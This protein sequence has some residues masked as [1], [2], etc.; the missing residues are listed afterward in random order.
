MAFPAIISASD[1][2]AVRLALGLATTDTTTLPDA[3]ITSRLFGPWVERQVQR[4]VTNWDDVID[5]FHA[6]YDADQE[7]ALQD[8][9]VLWIASRLAALYF[10][11]RAGEEVKK[12][13]LGPQSVEWR[14]PADWMDVATRLAADAATEL[15]RVT[16]WN[17][18]VPVI[19]LA[20]R[21]GPTQARSVAEEHMTP[22]AWEA[23]IAPDVIKERRW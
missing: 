14:D 5:N 12:A 17:N 13:T 10:A 3:T 8:G 7:A 18:E 20:T 1:Y 11:R 15:A 9:V 19:T 16:D 6:D 4:V 2:T 22:A 23:L 21:T